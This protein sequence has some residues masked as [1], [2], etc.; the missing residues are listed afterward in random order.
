[1]KRSRWTTWLA[2][3]LVPLLVAGGF[4]ELRH[5]DELKLLAAVS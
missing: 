1:M 2:L 4:L 5:A 3:L